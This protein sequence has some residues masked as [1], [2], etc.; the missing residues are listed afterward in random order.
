MMPLLVIFTSAALLAL[1][2]TRR[3]RE[4]ALSHEIMDVPNER[5]SHV[6]ATPRGGGVA[7]AA[8]VTLGSVILVLSNRVEPVPYGLMVA[9]GLAVAGIGF[10]DDSRGL[11]RWP[12]IAVQACAAAAMLAGVATAGTLTVPVF[13]DGRLLAWP[14]ALLALLWLVNLFNFMDGIDGLAGTEAVFVSLGM[15]TCLQVVGPGPSG[16][17]LL[18]A[19]V[20]GATSGFLVLNWPPARI[21]MGDAGSAFLGLVLGALSIIAHFETGISLWVPTILLGAF[22]TDATVTLLRRMILGER[23]YE[24]HRTHAYQRLSRRVG[25]HLPVTMGFLLANVIWLLPLAIVAACQ[26]DMAW[27]CAT[28]AYAPLILVALW[29]GAGRPELRQGTS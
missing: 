8:V 17:S 26:P 27:V 20:A 12:R 9:A 29:A 3:F 4:L 14:V 10:L 16:A 1:L 15:V 2:M 5:S 22:V 18:G 19:L 23:W 21:F 7:I 28:V 6:V 11:S 24:P 25:A 13:G